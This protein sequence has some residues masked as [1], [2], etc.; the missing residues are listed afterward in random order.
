[1]A[2]YALAQQGVLKRRKP[3]TVYQWLDRYEHHGL[4]GL[5]QQPRTPRGF[6]PSA[7]GRTP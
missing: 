6:P 3:D 7:G 5:V 4:A 2:A 1:M